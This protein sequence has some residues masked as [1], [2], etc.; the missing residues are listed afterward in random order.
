MYADTSF[1]SY[2][3]W[4]EPEW[5]VTGFEQEDVLQVYSSANYTYARAQISF[6][7]SPDVI[8]QAYLVPALLLVLCSY[9]GFFI[10]PMATPARVALGM[11]TIVVSANNYLGLTKQL[12]TT[13]T[14]PWIARLVLL[15]LYFNVIGMV[16]VV[17]VSFGSLSKKW[18]KAQEQL[19]DRQLPWRRA[20][21][22]HT[23]K[24]VEL[25]H[26]L[27]SDGN[28]QC[29]YT[30]TG[31]QLIEVNARMG[32]GP[33]RECNRLVWGVDLVEEAMFIALGIPARPVAPEQP[34]KCVGYSFVNAK[35][36]GKL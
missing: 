24:L 19:L 36:S 29:K 34:H 35:Q 9:F 11:L 15:C 16:G 31:P 18:L 1:D 3:R 7:R 20:L 22:L 32:G 8:I 14:P 2:L 5:Y 30:S 17:V 6:T 25:F 10:D 27:D 26:S 21:G 23:D 4:K 33:V 12:P 13:L 28:G